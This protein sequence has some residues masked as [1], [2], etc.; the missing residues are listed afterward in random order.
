MIIENFFGR[1]QK[2]FGVM[3]RK[4]GW[5]R[6]GL[7]DIVDVCFALTNFHIRLQPLREEDREYYYKVLSTMRA[8]KE[9][10]IFVFVFFL[11]NI[12]SNLLHHH[13]LEGCH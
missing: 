5:C 12:K 10:T 1:M 3:H 4:Y 6:E 8:K 9:V 13:Y 11:N 2:L 7:N